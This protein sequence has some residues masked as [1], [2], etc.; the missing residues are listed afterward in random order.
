MTAQEINTLIGY[1][2]T[3]KARLY[4]KKQAIPQRLKTLQECLPAVNQDEKTLKFF[5]ENFSTEIGA[6]MM[7]EQ[8]LEKAEHLYRAAKSY[9]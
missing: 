5:K 2:A 4:L 8:D 7:A 1:G 9:K 3:D 6:I